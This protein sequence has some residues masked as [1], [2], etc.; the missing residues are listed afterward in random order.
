ML[1]VLPASRAR[2]R[3]TISVVASSAPCARPC[4]RPNGTFGRVTVR[5][6]L[7]NNGDLAEIQ[8]LEPSGKPG[9]DQNVVFSTKQAYFPLPPNGST[10]IDRTFLITYVYR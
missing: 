6:V 5:L 1:R 3:T 7:N 9:L 2:A 8:V 4:R 10:V